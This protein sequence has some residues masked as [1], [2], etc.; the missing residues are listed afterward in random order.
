MMSSTGAG[1]IYDLFDNFQERVSLWK[2]V[3]RSKKKLSESSDLI[4]PDSTSAGSEQKRCG[5]V[6]TLN[7][8]VACGLV[9]VQSSGQV[10]RRIP[11]TWIAETIE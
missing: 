5:F 7:D 2:E 10:V 3:K 6:T 8:S 9:S 1:H 11:Y 4:P